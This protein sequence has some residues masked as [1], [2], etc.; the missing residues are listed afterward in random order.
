MIAPM[1]IQDRAAQVIGAIPAI[2]APTLQRA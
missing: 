2:D 1:D